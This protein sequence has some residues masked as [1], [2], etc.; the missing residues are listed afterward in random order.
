MPASIVLAA[1]QGRV[2]PSG[3]AARVAPSAPASTSFLRSFQIGLEKLQ[4]EVARK[5]VS[6]A[7]APAAAPD[8]PTESYM[9]RHSYSSG[10]SADVC[11][12]G[13]S[14]R[15]SP[16]HPSPPLGLN[17]GLACGG[18]SH[19]SHPNA[20]FPASSPLP[21]VMAPSRA[22]NPSQAHASASAFAPSPSHV[23]SHVSDSRCAPIA[24]ATVLDAIPASGTLPPPPHSRSSPGTTL[25][26]DENTCAYHSLDGRRRSQFCHNGM[27]G[28]GAGVPAVC[29]PCQHL[30]LLSVCAFVS[31]CAST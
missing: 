3:T 29:L 17:L 13:G 25:Y 1:N 30:T 28:S 6:K 26:G 8:L 23:P 24:T 20:H 4:D 18:H 27:V 22:P 31:T 5:V 21:I 10:P 7:A 11:A 16:R 12:S 9:A 19:G 14:R 2:R 15:A